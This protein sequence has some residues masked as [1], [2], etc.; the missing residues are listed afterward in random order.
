MIS[1]TCTIARLSMIIF[2]RLNMIQVVLTEKRFEKQ[3]KMNIPFIKKNVGLSNTKFDKNN[4]LKK[5]LY[6]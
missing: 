6:L 2:N 3:L 5:L 4:A 1:K